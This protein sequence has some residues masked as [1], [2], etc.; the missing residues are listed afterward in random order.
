[1]KPTSHALILESLRM[2]KSAFPDQYWGDSKWQEVEK[3]W[4]KQLQQYSPQAILHAC[5]R[6][7]EGRGFPKLV[8]LKKLCYSA[9]TL[10][11]KARAP[12]Q[13][14][15]QEHYRPPT[16]HPVFE[17]LAQ[18]WESENKT[19]SDPL[20]TEVAVNRTRELAALWAVHAGRGGR[21]R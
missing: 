2:L 12:T 11:P 9:E 8:D 5:G 17:A 1:M 21:K 13:Q 4:P 20:P 14:P 19:L 7:V 10:I 6:A 15:A 18:R 3:Y 16:Q